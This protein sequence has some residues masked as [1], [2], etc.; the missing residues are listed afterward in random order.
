MLKAKP[1][2][3]QITAILTILSISFTSIPQAQAVSAIDSKSASRVSRDVMALQIPKHLGVVSERHSKS[4]NFVV[5][6]EDAHSIPNAQVQIKG[7]IEYLTQ[8]YGIRLVVTEGAFGRLDSTFLKSFPDQKKLNQVLDEYAKVGELTGVNHAA[9]L[10]QTNTRF[11]GIEDHTLYEEGIRLYLEVLAQKEKLLK[12]L[13]VK[14]EKLKIKKQKT[15]S[16]KLFRFDCAAQSFDDHKLPLIDFLQFLA[17]IKPPKPESVLTH[18]LDQKETQKNN[19]KPEL[20]AASFILELNAYIKSVK[21]SLIVTQKERRLNWETEKLK[22]L[23]RLAKLELTYGDWQRI[24]HKKINSHFQTHFNFY[25]NTE[26]RDQAFLKRLKAQ[27]KCSPTIFV[28]GGFHTKSLT[29][30]L[31]QLGI[32]YLL[33][34]PQI[35][36]L[37]LESLYQKQMQ[38]EVSWKEYYRIKNGNIN[39]YEAFV[40][41][42][43]DR[44]VVGVGSQPTR[45]GTLQSIPRTG[46]EPAPT[47][48]SWRD[49]IILELAAHGGISKS[50]RYTRFLDELNQPEHLP[51]P[52]WIQRVNQFIEGLKTLEVRHEL[53]ELHI[54]KLLQPSNILPVSLGLIQSDGFVSADLIQPTRA[55]STQ[56]I[57]GGHNSSIHSELRA[58]NQKSGKPKQTERTIK[59]QTKE[60]KMQNHG[61]MRRFWSQKKWYL[62]AA[63]LIAVASVI[64]WMNPK[65]TEITVEGLR[66]EANAIRNQS[67]SRLTFTGDSPEV[68]DGP[69]HG[70]RRV[71]VSGVHSSPKTAD[72]LLRFVPE[73]LEHPN[74]WLFFIEPLNRPDDSSSPHPEEHIAVRLAHAKQIPLMDPI[75]DPWDQEVTNRLQKKID[76]DSTEFGIAYVY[77]N[78]SSLLPLAMNRATLPEVLEKIDEAVNLEIK[79]RG[80][81]KASFIRALAIKSA[82]IFQNS[83]EL[84]RFGERAFEISR[85][86]IRTV[87]EVGSERIDTQLEKTTKKNILFL[88]GGLHS[89]VVGGESLDSQLGS[90]NYGPGQQKDFNAKAL[91][92]ISWYQS[93]PEYAQLTKLRQELRNIQLNSETGGSSRF[94]EESRDFKIIWEGGV[95]TRPSVSLFMLSELAKQV[96]GVSVKINETQFY[97]HVGIFWLHIEHGDTITVTVAGHGDTPQTILDLFQKLISDPYYDETPFSPKMEVQSR[98]Q[99]YKAVIDAL[100]EKWNRLELRHSNSELSKARLQ[101]LRIAVTGA[102][103]H[104]GSVLLDALQPQAKVL[105]SVFR[106]ENEHKPFAQTFAHFFNTAKPV[107]SNLPN[108]AVQKHDELLALDSKDIKALIDLLSTLQHKGLKYAKNMIPQKSGPRGNENASKRRAE[109][110][111][112]RTFEY[113]WNKLIENQKWR[114]IRVSGKRWDFLIQLT[115]GSPDWH[116]PHYEYYFL[117]AS[118]DQVGH[119]E[120]PDLTGGIATSSFT[121]YLPAPGSEW[122]KPAK[123]DFVIKPEF[124]PIAKQADLKRFAIILWL[125]LAKKKEINHLLIEIPENADELDMLKSIGFREPY[126]GEIAEKGH[127]LIFNLDLDKVPNLPITFTR[128]WNPRHDRFEMQNESSE[129]QD[130]SDEREAQEVIKRFFSL[131]AL[132]HFQSLINTVLLNLNYLERAV[133]HLPDQAANFTDRDKGRQIIRIIQ[134]AIQAITS[135]GTHFSLEHNTFERA[136]NAMNSLEP[137]LAST[138]LKPFV[139]TVKASLSE[140]ARVAYT[141]VPSNDRAA[142][143]FM[144]WL[145]NNEFYKPAPVVFQT[146]KNDFQHVHTSDHVKVFVAS[147]PVQ[148]EEFAPILDND[149]FMAQKEFVTNFESSGALKAILF[150]RS[151]D[152]KNSAALDLLSRGKGPL[153]LVLVQFPDQPENQ[154]VLIGM[155][156]KGAVPIQLLF[157]SRS[158]F[159]QSLFVEA[160]WKGVSPE[161]TQGTIPS[162][163]VANRYILPMEIKLEGESISLSGEGPL[164]SLRGLESVQNQVKQIVSQEFPIDRLTLYGLSNYLPI[165]SSSFM[166]GSII[167]DAFRAAVRLLTR[168]NEEILEG[169]LTSKVKNDVELVRLISFLDQ[170]LKTLNYFAG[171]LSELDREAQ[172]T[173]FAFYSFVVASC[174]IIVTELLGRPSTAPYLSICYHISRMAENFIKTGIVLRDTNPANLIHVFTLFQ[175]LLNAMMRENRFPEFHPVLERVSRQLEEEVKRRVLQVPWGLMLGGQTIADPQHQLGSGENIDQVDQVSGADSGNRHELRSGSRTEMRRA[176]SSEKRGDSST[177]ANSERMKADRESRVPKKIRLV[178]S[179]RLLNRC[180]MLLAGVGLLFGGTI[181]ILRYLRTH[182]SVKTETPGKNI[183]KSAEIAAQ[184]SSFEVHG[185][186]G[187]HGSYKHAQK[188]IA[189]LKEAAKNESRV[190]A[191]VQKE[192][193]LVPIFSQTRQAVLRPITNRILILEYAAS[194]SDLIKHLRDTYQI[195]I[196]AWNDLKRMVQDENQKRVLERYYVSYLERMEQTMNTED[197]RKLVL[198]FSHSDLTHKLHGYQRSLHRYAV[199]TNSLIVLEKIPFDVWLKVM[200]FDEIK[201]VEGSAA[202]P[203]NQNG[204]VLESFFKREREALIQ[205]H[206]EL[207]R[208]RDLRFNELPTDSSQHLPEYVRPIALQWPNYKTSFVRGSVHLADNPELSSGLGM[209]KRYTFFDTWGDFTTELE[210]N[211]KVKRGEGLSHSEILDFYVLTK[212]VL[213]IENIFL[214]ED[215]DPILTV[216]KE[217]VVLMDE[218]KL[219]AMLQEWN[220][221]L[222]NILRNKAEFD[223]EINGKIQR[224]QPLDLSEV[225][226]RLT[227]IIDRRPYW[228]EVAGDVLPEQSRK[229]IGER[230]SEERKRTVQEWMDWILEANGRNQQKLA[231]G[232]TSG[233]RQELRDSKLWLTDE[234]FTVKTTKEKLHKELD[235]LMEYVFNRLAQSDQVK[236]DEANSDQLKWDVLLKYGDRLAKNPD[237]SNVLFRENLK[238]P[239]TKL[240]ILTG[241]VMEYLTK[242]RFSEASVFVEILLLKINSS[243]LPKMRYLNCEWAFTL[244]LAGEWLSYHTMYL[245]SDHIYESRLKAVWPFLTLREKMMRLAL[246]GPHMRTWFEYID[247]SKD[248]WNFHP[249]S[250]RFDSVEIIYFVSLLDDLVQDLLH[251]NSDGLHSLLKGVL[252]F[253]LIPPIIRYTDA[254]IVSN[255]LVVTINPFIF[256]F[257]EWLK[258]IESVLQ[259]KVST[260]ELNKFKTVIKNLL[261]QEKIVKTL[262]GKLLVNTSLP[263]YIN[264]FF[265]DISCETAELISQ[266]NREHHNQPISFWQ[267]VSGNRRAND[268]VRKNNGARLLDNWQREQMKKQME[269][270][271]QFLVDWLDKAPRTEVRN[272]L[273]NQKPLGAG[274]GARR[275]LRSGSVTRDQVD[276]LAQEEV[277]K[278]RNLFFGPDADTVFF[279]QIK[280]PFERGRFYVAE[281]FYDFGRNL[282]TAHP[283]KVEDDNASGVSNVKA[284]DVSKVFVKRQ[285]HTAFR[286]GVAEDFFIGG[287][288]QAFFIGGFNIHLKFREFADN[289]EMDTMVNEDFHGTSLRRADDSRRFLTQMARK[290]NRSENI[291]LGKMRIFIRDFLDRIT[292]SKEIENVTDRNSSSVN[293]RF[294]KTNR[295]ID[296][297]FGQVSFLHQA[298]LS[299][300]KIVSDGL[301]YNIVGTGFRVVRLAH[302]STEPAPSKQAP[303]ARSP[304]KIDQMRAEMRESSQASDHLSDLWPIDQ[305]LTPIYPG[306]FHPPFGTAIPE[307]VI[308][309]IAAGILAQSHRWFADFFH[310]SGSLQ[311]SFIKGGAFSHI[312]KIHAFG[313]QNLAVLELPTHLEPTHASTIVHNYNNFKYYWDQG[314]RRYIPEPFNLSY[315]HLVMK[316]SGDRKERQAI[317]IPQGIYQFLD[318]YEELNYGFGALR[319]WD[320]KF[321]DTRGTMIPLTQEETM[322]ALTEIIAAVVYHYEPEVN[323]GRTIRDIYL[324]NGDFIYK[325]RQDGKAEIKWITMRDHEENIGITEFIQQLL[326]FQTREFIKPDDIK[327]H[328]TK[329][330]SY[331]WDA[332]ILLVNP[333]IVFH[334]I[335]RGLTYRYQDLKIENSSGKAIRDTREWLQTFSSVHPEYKEWVDRFLNTSQLGENLPLEWGKDPR[336]GQM[337]FAH[338]FDVE[339]QTKN[340]LKATPS[341]AT[342]EQVAQVYAWIRERIHWE[343]DTRFLRLLITNFK[344][345]KT[346]THASLLIEVEEVL[347]GNKNISP[348]GWRNIFAD[349]QISASPKQI[350]DFVTRLEEV[351]KQTDVDSQKLRQKWNWMKEN[352]LKGQVP[353]TGSGDRRELRGQMTRFAIGAASSFMLGIAVW[354]VY[355][356][357]AKKEQSRAVILSEAKDLTSARFFGLHPQ[358]DINMQNSNHSLNDPLT[359]LSKRWRDGLHG[360]FKNRDGQGLK[361]DPTRDR[362]RLIRRWLYGND[363]NSERAFE[364]LYQDREKAVNLL[365]EYLWSENVDEWKRAMQTAGKFKVDRAFPSLELLIEDALTKGH[366]YKLTFALQAAAQIHP[367]EMIDTLSEFILS[368]NPELAGVG[369]HSV[370]ALGVHASSVLPAL[371][372]YLDQVLSMDAYT[373]SDRYQAQALIKMLPEINP[374]E[375][376]DILERLID[377]HTPKPIPIIE[378]PRDP[379]LDRS[380]SH[381]G[382]D[383]TLVTI[384]LVHLG[385]TQTIQSWSVKI[386]NEDGSDKRLLVDDHPLG[387]IGESEGRLNI[388]EEIKMGQYLR[389]QVSAP[390]GE[391]LLKEAEGQLK[392]IEEEMPRNELRN[393][394]PLGAGSKARQELRNYARTKLRKNPEELLDQPVPLG[395]LGAGEEFA[396][397]LVRGLAQFGFVEPNQKI[398]AAVHSIHNGRGSYVIQKDIQRLWETFWWVRGW[399]FFTNH[400]PKQAEKAEAGLRKYFG[401]ELIKTLPSSSVSMHQFGEGYQDEAWDSILLYRP[402][403]ER[404][405]ARDIVDE[406]K[407]LAKKNYSLKQDTALEK[408]FKDIDK[409]IYRLDAKTSERRLRALRKKVEA[410]TL[411]IERDTGIRHPRTKDFKILF[412]WLDY[413]A[414]LVD[415]K[416]VFQTPSVD[417]SGRERRPG[418]KL[419]PINVQGILGFGV[420]LEA[421]E[422]GWISYKKYRQGLNHLAKILK[423]PAIAFHSS[424]KS[425]FDTTLVAEMNQDIEVVWPNGTVSRTDKVLGQFNLKKLKHL[426]IKNIHVV[427]PVTRQPVSLPA[428]PETLELIRKAERLILAPEHLDELAA[429]LS[430]KEIASALVA[431]KAAFSETK[432]VTYLMI[433]PTT[434]NGSSPL[435]SLDVERRLIDATGFGIADIANYVLINN[436]EMEAKPELKE[437]FKRALELEHIEATHVDDSLIQYLKSPS[438]SVRVYQAPL[439]ELIKLPFK[440]GNEWETTYGFA[441]NRLTTLL[442]LFDIYHRGEAPIWVSDVDGTFKK[443]GHDHPI[444]KLMAELLAS[445]IVAKAPFI[446]LTGSSF[447]AIKKNV[448]D[449]IREYLADKNALA[450]LPILTVAGSLTHAYDLSTGQHEFVF[451][452]N[453]PELLG[454]EGLKQFLE[455]MNDVVAKPVVNKQTLAERNLALGLKGNDGSGFWGSPL[456]SKIPAGFTIALTGSKTP[457]EVSRE[458]AVNPGRDFNLPYIVYLNACLRSVFEKLGVFFNV[459]MGSPI[460]VDITVQGWDKRKGMT[461][462][463]EMASKPIWA[464]IFSGDNIATSKEGM[465]AN[466]TSAAETVE[467]SVNVNPNVSPN[468]EGRT[469]V[470]ATEAGEDDGLAESIVIYRE[471]YKQIIPDE[472]KNF[473]S[474]FA[475][476]VQR[477]KEEALKNTESWAEKQ[478]T[479]FFTTSSPSHLSNDQLNDLLKASEVLIVKGAPEK[480]LLAYTVLKQL[481]KLTF[482]NLP[483][484]QR[485]EWMRRIAKGMR[486]YARRS[487][488]T[489]YNKYLKMYQ[490]GK[491]GLDTNQDSANNLQLVESVPFWDAQ[492]REARTVAGRE[493]FSSGKVG[494]QIILADEKLNQE[495]F[496]LHFQ[497]LKFLSD[498]L[499]NPSLQGLA[500]KQPERSNPNSLSSPHALSGDPGIMD[501]RFRGNDKVHSFDDIILE[502]L[503]RNDEAPKQLQINLVTTFLNHKEI[504]QALKENNYFGLNPNQVEIDLAPIY[505]S[506]DTVNQDPAFF[507]LRKRDIETHKSSRIF[508]TPGSLAS[509]LAPLRAGV[510]NRWK[511]EGVEHL[512]VTD[513]N[514]TIPSQKMFEAFRESDFLRLGTLINSGD[515]M[516]VSVLSRPPP[517]EKSTVLYFNQS[518]NHYELG[519]AHP[520]ESELSFKESSAVLSH[521]SRDVVS[522]GALLAQ[523]PS[524]EEKSIDEFAERLRAKPY[525]ER[526]EIEKKLGQDRTI[527]N[528]FRPYTLLTRILKTGYLRESNQSEARHEL[529][530]ILTRERASWRLGKKMRIRKEKEGVSFY[531]AVNVKTQAP[532][533]I[534]I[535][536]VASIRHFKTAAEMS[537]ALEE[538][539]KTKLPDTDLGNRHELR[540][541]DFKIG[542][543][544]EPWTENEFFTVPKTLN[545]LHRELDQL[546]DEVLNQLLQAGKISNI[547]GETHEKWA[548]LRKYGDKSKEGDDQTKIIFFGDLQLPQTKLAILTGAVVEYLTGLDQNQRETLLKPDSFVQVLLQAINASI[549]PGMR[550]L[551]SE[552]AYTFP[553]AGEWLTYHTMHLL[554]DEVYEARLKAIFPFLSLREKVMRFALFGPH[555]RNKPLE[556]FVLNHFAPRLDQSEIPLLISL[557]SNL[558]SE[559]FWSNYESNLK[560]L[561]MLRAMLNGLLIPSSVPFVDQKSGGKI[562][563]AYFSGWLLPIQK[564]LEETNKLESIQQLKSTLRDR[565][566]QDGILTSKNLSASPQLS[567]IF[568]PAYLAGYYGAISNQTAFNVSKYNRENLIKISLWDVLNGSP[569]ASEFIQ[570]FHLASTAPVAETF[571][572]R[573][574]LINKVRESMCQLITWLGENGPHTKMGKRLEL[575][576]HKNLQ[577]ELKQ[578]LS[579]FGNAVEHLRLDY[580]LENPSFQRALKEI[581]EQLSQIHWRLNMN[582]NQ[583]AFFNLGTPSLHE[584][585]RSLDSSMKS[586]NEAMKRLSDFESIEGMN[587]LKPVEVLREQ[588]GG[589]KM[590]LNKYERFQRSKE[591]NK[592]GGRAK[593]PVTAA[594]LMARGKRV[595]GYPPNPNRM[596]LRVKEVA[597]SVVSYFQGRNEIRMDELASKIEL[598]VQEFSVGDLVRSIEAVKAN[599]EEAEIK[600]EPKFSAVLLDPNKQKFLLSQLNIAL[601]RYLNENH[602]APDRKIAIAHESANTL[603]G[604]QVDSIYLDSLADLPVSRLVVLNCEGRLRG[605]SKLRK[606][607][608]TPVYWKAGKKAVQYYLPFGQELIGASLESARPEL[609]PEFIQLVSE[610]SVSEMSIQM[611]QISIVLQNI[612][613]VMIGLGESGI[614][615]DELLGDPIRLLR[616]YN[617]NLPAYLNGVISKHDNTLHFMFS[618]IEDALALEIRS[619]AA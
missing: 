421:S 571:I 105:T 8:K 451:G 94:H 70:V 224:R 45:N 529:R 87:N 577:V 237:H 175:T 379:S 10:D 394:E 541:D 236:S 133:S 559:F 534:Q 391:I 481:S 264:S 221:R 232:A 11:L 202:I 261:I 295:R 482:Q 263:I 364:A 82:Q 618:K 496:R 262:K 245:M 189:A 552:W 438:K 490:E 161:E 578:Q 83:L 348:G 613:A 407:E 591:E 321:P 21:A 126:S 459:V 598:I 197:F 357:Y 308:H 120:T 20:S 494:Y 422:P 586:F 267:V 410:R 589:L 149:S 420:M 81:D 272:E 397:P 293:A 162:V 190:D 593:P 283:F 42:V 600:F 435:I 61:S 380:Y 297:N 2:P 137:L 152:N 325:K 588:Y 101:N 339:R 282:I 52:L 439:C 270:S 383:G 172:Q 254:S 286:L 511:K 64:F 19:P 100:K 573:Q 36:A 49:Q 276:E 399:N 528:F 323:G 594:L 40:R 217:R 419:R 277:Q 452:V 166:V 495:L 359:E 412:L 521:I 332:P 147:V 446:P 280:R 285:D 14:K 144:Y 575:R 609:G 570:K 92:F 98:Y 497:Y 99:E 219:G 313:R 287:L 535:F 454:A 164:G 160:L 111:S 450:Y 72:A 143:N 25:Q 540:N 418:E 193:M 605:Y 163:Y 129:V 248:D 102:A 369:I 191:P 307:G 155:R 311:A 23:T 327:F 349:G 363:E 119:L 170:S 602:I 480:Q 290:L 95:H 390:T 135:Y 65:K 572:L 499:Q 165:L 39:V 619:A 569:K 167:P 242:V 467:T 68:L 125:Y 209:G 486:S 350:T 489:S 568:L 406:A 592:L 378:K 275:E 207:D 229:W 548:A 376:K 329:E 385:G 32:S 493:A 392:K 188:Q 367:L 44:L 37:P 601:S 269:H 360:N 607:G 268:F 38:G 183:L 43:R 292:S 265:Q 447:G 301:K 246:F 89:Q 478:V 353:D 136:E 464:F 595:R 530:G 66:K 260:N 128:A 411:E 281:K 182:K 249:F 384:K 284:G 247:A 157:P 604:A 90:Y 408:D 122:E 253:F 79:E 381:Q 581:D 522:L 473:T 60:K 278:L 142:E 108:A 169:A 234:F 389:S 509:L 427:D 171:K 366:Y 543:G 178:A 55:T 306:K 551:G 150:D 533:V 205:K 256:H 612:V 233:D 483:E 7:L 579:S 317:P 616:K 352:L 500:A 243:V 550:H 441:P 106:S 396:W 567:D 148:E 507:K 428:T 510:L 566:I 75:P 319:R 449:A 603:A 401:I 576:E 250:S 180:L 57:S 368:E 584:C 557:F 330:F 457:L 210:I 448:I 531:R 291:L 596:E 506:V 215:M 310:I 453:L 517:A 414:R 213:E 356:K 523:F 112:E 4:E 266:H 107:I 271:L 34:R 296:G 211:S 22:L 258:R 442:T 539:I 466:D 587:L 455:I 214:T 415:E 97:S 377:E 235:G 487:V 225:Q 159:V 274:S 240:A 424:L 342:R 110:R 338:L 400:F 337:L 580:T 320:I 326:Q 156:R 299:F 445:A 76:G 610:E 173:L 492:T 67:F 96:N 184:F 130:E 324:N 468:F 546:M 532:A 179:R 538:L 413:Y 474:Q 47:L 469:I 597:S 48:K 58:S 118:T 583:K 416:L 565:L 88:S 174:G 354:F 218:K 54:L 347:R 227:S 216:I 585:L 562:E 230:I 24:K 115:G 520:S 259:L 443:L 139:D 436:L 116:W 304:T 127:F 374:A 27:I 518:T 59:I 123:M 316:A 104:I 472:M 298:L 343:I 351:K 542:Q 194:P 346:Q 241:A 345:L 117:I 549:L 491:L 409:M 198:S 545:E 103:G 187:A 231:P 599:A 362:E 429:I 502:T 388:P 395:I 12:F 382:E 547:E 84:D 555:A 35:N 199:E 15:Y 41:A 196:F 328:P 503:S 53:S 257:N 69:W 456:M 365:F 28:S 361:I 252:N 192:D 524:V 512:L 561:A 153:E 62:I 186:F 185:V 334:G 544:F 470:T 303:G 273:R 426:P 181:L 614:S 51:E 6:V 331:G 458:F 498:S 340:H 553:L 373:D 251:V 56:R 404:S 9:I 31:K 398:Q 560:N 13:D 80:L 17:S 372:E 519:Y 312:I 608:I 18:L 146:N 29:K 63:G 212:I 375:A 226:S 485:V 525:V 440:M 222:M 223:R 554:D 132:I 220:K 85:E 289:F 203:L 333:S 341:F 526:I 33:V 431:R 30:Q 26:L 208:P 3:N 444:S 200:L 322:D 471:L 279:D 476:G 201:K 405:L 461:S 238:F 358:N 93:H 121:L 309:E 158:P 432:K 430:Q 195:P 590:L 417:I 204:E 355:F 168:A 151:S 536:D 477:K 294:S 387:R 335:L 434:R 288:I 463:A 505:Q 425:A 574:M 131:A 558:V 433:P 582:E 74:D 114:S 140:I 239:E 513:L 515:E 176:R 462:I 124:E 46:L 315:A 617:P 606:M 423:S 305:L 206:L 465:P 371:E 611:R 50:A 403:M 563:M 113:F 5:L 370:W 508:H 386:V 564:K 318:G 344:I 479:G 73:I 314:L 1:I 484:A 504:L 514:G 145:P 228:I 393:L 77:R 460:H 86:T 437:K 488:E 138:A 71:M 556:G 501:S 16:E 527:D 78:I 302:H 300:K 141:R 109:L 475:E 91:L 177:R 244:P 336:E 255:G 615:Q 402:S 537:Q 154:L 134:L 516:L